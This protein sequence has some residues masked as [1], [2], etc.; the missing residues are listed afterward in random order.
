[1][2]ARASALLVTAKGGQMA[3]FRIMHHGTIS[4]VTPLTNRCKAWLDEKVE[5]E[6]W[7]WFGDQLAVEPRYVDQVVEGMIEDGLMIE[8][9]G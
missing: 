9:D 6:G 4:T 8:R 3:D 5:A 7:Q 1:M 2:P